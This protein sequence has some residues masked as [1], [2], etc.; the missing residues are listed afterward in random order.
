[1]AHGS[2]RGTQT[3]IYEAHQ[4]PLANGL[5]YNGVLSDGGYAAVFESIG[6]HQ[7]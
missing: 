5:M 4:K 3:V 2:T 1:V 6:Y 7:D